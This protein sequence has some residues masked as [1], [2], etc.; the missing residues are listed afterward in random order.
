MNTP[1]V[2][3]CY[4]LEVFDRQVW[5]LRP[6]LSFWQGEL[7]GSHEVLVQGFANETTG[8]MCCPY[9]MIPT[10]KGVELCELLGEQDPSAQNQQATKL[11]HLS[12]GELSHQDQHVIFGFVKCGIGESSQDGF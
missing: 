4:E 1:K 3:W 7:P 12:T 10:R 11:S 6:A 5:F 8:A 2:A 9:K